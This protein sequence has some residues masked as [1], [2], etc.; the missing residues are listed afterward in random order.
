M[1]H[2]GTCRC[3]PTPRL[4]IPEP[5]ARK[6]LPRVLPHVTDLLADDA[7]PYLLNSGAVT[8]EEVEGRLIRAES[9]QWSLQEVG[10]RVTE[11]VAGDSPALLDAAIRRLTGLAEDAIALSA[12]IS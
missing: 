3:T 7:G 8:A 9:L 1:I 12:A 2:C 6:R 5:R 10:E 11:A 4:N